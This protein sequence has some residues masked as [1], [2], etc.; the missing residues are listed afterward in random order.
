[1]SWHRVLPVTLWGKTR[2]ARKV[3]KRGPK[4]AYLFVY[5]SVAGDPGEVEMN[6]TLLG[7]GSM[8]AFPRTVEMK[9]AQKTHI[10]MLPYKHC[11]E[12]SGCQQD[13]FQQFL[14][15]LL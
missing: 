1:M 7:V 8:A 3:Q 12:T 11:H 5:K 15:M 13:P 4:P 14:G 9:P 2:K 10:L 6:W